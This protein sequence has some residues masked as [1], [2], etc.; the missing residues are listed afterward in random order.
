MTPLVSIII[1]CYRQGRFLAEA[2]ESALAQSYAAVEVIVVNDGSD[3][4]TDAVAR[5]YAER[6]CYIAQPN[7]GVSVARNAGMAAAR[8]DFLLFL[9]ADD[10]LRPDAVRRMVAATQG[11][12]R[13]VVQGWQCFDDDAPA[14]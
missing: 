4:D 8:G 1:P 2:I 6:I 13:L 3:D 9:D 7:C 11:E 14:S 5:H 12:E 10:L